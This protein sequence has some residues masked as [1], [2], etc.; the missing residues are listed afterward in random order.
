ME[1]ANG[2][3]AR[4]DFRQVG[5]N[6]KIEMVIRTNGGSTKPSGC[7]SYAQHDQI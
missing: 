2:N 4:Y 3:R 7:I 1:I 6:M 5:I